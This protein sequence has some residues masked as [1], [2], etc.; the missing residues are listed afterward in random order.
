M[1]T[2][3]IQYGEELISRQIFFD[4]NISQYTVY[5]YISDF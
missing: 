2:M 5:I 4:M 3:K 1:L